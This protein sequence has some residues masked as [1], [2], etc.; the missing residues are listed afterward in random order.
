MATKQL[1]RMA[2]KCVK[3]EKAE[4]VK[5]KKAIQAGNMEN[6]RIHAENAIRQ[7]NQGINFLRM[8]A[9]V[10]AVAQRVQTAVTMKQVTASMKGVVKSMDSAMRSMNLVQISALMDKFEKQFEDLDVQSKYMEGAMAS[11]VTTATPESQVESLMSEVADEHGLEL[12]M[13]LGS[14]NVPVGTTSTANAEQDELTERLA[15]LRES[16]N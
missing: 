9:R 4:K 2:K 10:D 5:L 7:K 1:E 15:R 11:T 3:D 6:A 8:S 12:N 13:E 14:H 16:S